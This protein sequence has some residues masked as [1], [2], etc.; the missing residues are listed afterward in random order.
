MTGQRTSK[1]IETKNKLINEKCARVGKTCSNSQKLTTS[2]RPGKGLTFQ[3]KLLNFIIDFKLIK[4]LF[5]GQKILGEI[6][7]FIGLAHHSAS[8]SSF[9]SKHSDPPYPYDIQ[10]LHI[11][12]MESP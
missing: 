9:I 4:F 8:A 1:V 6:S 11:N 7:T 3:L 5:L 10:I 12:R 2:P